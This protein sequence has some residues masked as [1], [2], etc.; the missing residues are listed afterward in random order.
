M[1]EYSPIQKYDLLNSFM[2]VLVPLSFL[3]IIISIFMFGGLFVNKAILILNLLISAYL[4][5]RIY[6]SSYH[7][8]FSYDRK[9][10]NLEKGKKKKIQGRW[11]DFDR[12]SYAYTG[13]NEFE[14]RLYKKKGKEYVPET[15]IPATK[16]GLNA[17]DF[18]FEVMNF[19]KD[20]R[21]NF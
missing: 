9:S 7:M 20:E 18:R 16:L 4:G 17:S 6:K 11:K 3:T 15:K 8:K 19:I 5:Y 12:V 14:I 10:F 2:Y 13:Y 1:K 21:Y